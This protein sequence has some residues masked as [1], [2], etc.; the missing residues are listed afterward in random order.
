MRYRIA[1]YVVLSIFCSTI[2]VNA[3]CNTEDAKNHVKSFYNWYLS[4]KN[5]KKT[6]LYDNAIYKY[7]DNCTV[8]NVR[9]YY[10]RGRLDYDYFTKSQDYNIDWIDVMTVHEA[11]KINDTTSFVPVSFNISKI[12]QNNLIVFVKNTSDGIRITKITT[13]D[14]P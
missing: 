7:I 12:G 6:A 13:T 11:T 14:T 8:N 5:F 2:P 4:W 1:V 9:I 10:N 3:C